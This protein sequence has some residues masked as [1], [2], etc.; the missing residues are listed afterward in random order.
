M[1]AL[2]FYVYAVFILTVITAIGLFFRAAHYS[3]PLLLIIAV[4]MILQ[5]ILGRNNFYIINTVPPRFL[6]LAVPP[7]LLLMMLL[8]IPAGRRFI[9][10]LHVGTLTL[11][12]TVR[13]PVE[14]VLYWLFIHK[15]IPAVMTFEGRNF[16]I[17]SGLSAP[18]IW[19]WGIVKGRLNKTFLLVWN[20][21]CL[22]L[23]LNIVA[24]SIHAAASTFTPFAIGYFPFMLLPGC[25]VPLV[26]YSHVA[27]IRQ[28][29]IK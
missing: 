3:K 22:A 17:L 5:S 14:I 19:Y 6:L 2:P 27:A 8:A 21:A 15:T 26:L 10:N 20:L 7:L 18:F 4:W 1:Q 25:L 12:H 23:L 13:I 24:I 9:D 28:L 29:L 11:L 16:D